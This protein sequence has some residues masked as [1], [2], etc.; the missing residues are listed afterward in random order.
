MSG[1]PIR[2]AVA[3]AFVTLT[4][5]GCG[6][7]AVPPPRSGVASTA[8][9]AAPTPSSAPQPQAPPE[10]V[11]VQAGDTLY[12]VSRRTN[13]PIRAIIDANNLSPPFALRQGQQLVVPHPQVHVV[14]A[15]ETLYSISRQNGVDV[16]TL[17]QSNDLQPPY[18][19][20]VGQ[21]LILPARVAT[22][23]PSASSASASE[24]QHVELLP[25]PNIGAVG[26]QPLPTA[27]PAASAGAPGPSAEVPSSPNGIVAVPLPPP[28]PLQPPQPS[29]APATGQAVPPALP[30]PPTSPPLAAAPPPPPPTANLGVI[31]LPP[32]PASAASSGSN[33]A[34]NG[35]GAMDDGG[36]AAPPG[37]VASLSNESSPRAGGTK[38]GSFL[39][40]IKGKIL[41]SYGPKEG[42]LFNDGINIGAKEGENVIAAEGGVVVYAGNEIRGF[43]NLVLI[44]HAN[45]W[46]TA[47]AHND[48]LLVTRGQEVKRGQP[49]AKAGATGSVSTPQ[50]HFELRRGSRPVDPIRYMAALPS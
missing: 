15:G 21:Q 19:V 49:I 28:A 1:A 23:A 35:T 4:L 3:F 31:P 6:Y 13:V 17:V 36:D 38:G 37:R 45:G 30:I 11:T 40:P 10:S 46:M 5:A 33:A 25:P 29:S 12:A 50:V 22:V 2:L 32:P 42:G 34:A 24:V 44:K 14:Q 43:G 47:Y 27:P 41:S 39:W 7:L 18:K 8:P 48:K 20:L 26:T 9:V 16:S